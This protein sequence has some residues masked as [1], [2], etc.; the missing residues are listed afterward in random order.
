MIPD[1]LYR[2]RSMAALLDDF[3]ELERR[4]I[5]F[6]KPNELNDPMEGYK[7]VVW[8]GD[9]VLWE[10]LLRH[11]VLAL[12]WVMTQFLVVSDDMPFQEPTIPSALT[13]AD[14]PTDA[15]RALYRDICS[16][17]FAGA[18]AGALRDRLATLSRPVRADGVRALLSLVHVDA[19]AAVTTLM[20]RNGLMK[21]GSADIVSKATSATDIDVLFKA[22]TDA[23]DAHLE[24]A[25]LAANHV[26]DAQALKALF[27]LDR[28]GA[29]AGR[30]G[31]A[32]YLMFT[33]PDRYVNAV[34]E[35]L[36]H[37]PWRTACFSTTC[38]NASSWAVYGREHTG[39]AL[40]FRPRVDE[41]GPFIPLVGVNSVSSVVGKPDKKGRGDIRGELYPVTYANKPP[42]IDFFQSLGTLPPVKL[43]RAW[44]ANRDGKRSP[45]IDAA[46]TDKAAWRAAYWESFNRTA[47]TKLTD[48]KHEEEWRIV[49]SDIMGLRTDI[50]DAN[51]E[52][53]FSCLVGIVFGLR[54]KQHHKLAVMKLIAAECERAGRSDFEFHQMTYAPSKGCLVRL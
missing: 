33:F 31:R 49:M 2:F 16:D 32:T 17:F 9:A 24:V 5:Y 28:A 41:H 39:A 54:T 1:V 20:K 21:P 36:V 29:V 42:E 38:T 3:H 8:R 34:V 10:N 25:M 44:H 4:Q 52:Y 40:V 15:M 46:A 45:I 11:Y 50:A 23:S 51:F 19:V 13:D 26:R 43:D 47:T 6:A 18:T 22:Y 53:D 30:A 27:Q 48:W 14:L 35:H 37:P 12:L 7:D